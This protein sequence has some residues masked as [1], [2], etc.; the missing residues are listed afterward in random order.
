MLIEHLALTFVNTIRGF[1]ARAANT[2]RI[3]LFNLIL[4]THLQKLK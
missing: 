2:G 1:F 4:S 3:I